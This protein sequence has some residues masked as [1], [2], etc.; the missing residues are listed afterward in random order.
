[1]GKDLGISKEDIADCKGAGELVETVAQAIGENRMLLV[2]DD[3]WAT[4]AGEPFMIGAPNCTRI[5][6]TRYKNIARELMPDADSVLEVRKLTPQ[7]GFQLLSELAPHAARVAPEALHQLARHVDGLPIALVLIGKMLKREGDD[8]QATHTLLQTLADIGHVFHEKKPLEYA[9]THN[10]SLGEVVEASYSALGRAGPLSRCEIPGEQLRKALDALSVLRPDPAWF[11]V[12]LARLVSGA[13]DKALKALVD[14]GLIETV[15]YH[16]G[17]DKPDHSARYTMHRMI[18]EYIRAKLPPQRLQELNRLAAGYYLERL[19]DM[20]KSYQADEAT[21][22]KV[23]YRYEDPEWQDCQDNWL[24]Y[25]AQT[26]YDSEANISFLRAWF[27]GFWWWSCFTAEGYDFCDEL[28]ND[29]DYR[30]SLSTSSNTTAVSLNR[31]R[32]ERIMHGLELLRRFKR[33]Y[34]KETEDRSGGAWMDVSETL[35]ELRQRAGLDVDLALLP[36]PHAHHVRALTD[37]FL[38]EA[39]RFGHGNIAAAETYYREALALFRAA[40]K[41][42]EKED[43][44][45]AWALY[46]LADMLGGCEAAERREEAQ[47]LGLEATEVGRANSDHEVVALAHRLLGDIALTAKN[48]GD[49]LHHYLLAVE[50]AY[51]FQVHP[52]NPDPYTIQFYADLSG[53]V[54][55]RLLANYATM[56]ELAQPVMEG[57]RQAWLDSGAELEPLSHE[58][59][60]LGEITVQRLVRQI[61]PPSLPLERL[62]AEGDAYAE[63]VKAHLAAINAGRPGLP[64]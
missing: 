30:L 17:D 50:S 10:F 14:A 27:D 16:P 51:R 2:I 28:L 38:A 47:A 36:G 52:E 12:A 43:W 57:L 24:Y 15:L 1:M 62:K 41:E 39:E 19:T 25:F 23:M 61:F 45:V 55:G 3:V 11:P 49:A 13:P 29:W 63:R 34:P 44:N 58:D 40:K 53:W 26:G 46:H 7:E 42:G 6:T 48:G 35:N 5:I 64:G 31:D 54:A 32:I 20:E 9:E 60:Q 18:S 33:A 21:S 37:I 59:L 56:P 4:E 22:Y 8:E